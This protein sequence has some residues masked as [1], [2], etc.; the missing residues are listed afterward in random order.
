[1]L[2]PVCGVVV[3]FGVSVVCIVRCCAGVLVGFFWV[4]PLAGCAVVVFGVVIV[5][6]QRCVLFYK[7]S[8]LS[9]RWV[10]RSS[11]KGH[12]R[13]GCPPKIKVPQSCRM[14]KHVQPMSPN[15][16]FRFV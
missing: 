15:A 2:Y 12:D 16:I 14:L 8:C 10:M 9:L 1:M 13:V 5:Y 4:G 7:L 3:L 11:S 6:V